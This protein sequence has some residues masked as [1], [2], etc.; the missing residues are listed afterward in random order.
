MR[1]LV[2]GGTGFTGKALVRRLLNDG[3]SVIAMDYKEG[4]KTQELRDWGAEVVI[5]SVTDRE[6]VKQCM[7]GVE[8]VQHVAAAF[9][10]MNVPESYYD[11]VNVGGTRICL[12]EAMAAGVKKFIYCSTCGVHG[13][14]KNPPTDEA[15]NIAPADYYQQTKYNA[16]PVVKS[17]H[18]KGL[19]C[20]ILRPSAIYGPGDPERFFMIYRRAAKGVFPMFGGGKTLYHPV[21]IDNLVDAMVLAMAPGKGD[22][23]V[24]L[25]ADAEYIP[26]EDLVK[27]IGKAMG[28]DVKIKHYPVW[29][30]VIAGHVCEKICKPFKIAP[31]I[32]PRRVDW[33]RQNRAFDISA[34]RRDLGYDP[35]VGLDEGLKR[36]FEWYKQEKYL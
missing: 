3:H 24:Y 20:V 30:L 27:R 16:E 4:I 18:E 22:G 26:I 12:E 36:T 5:G 15:H 11:E 21:Y 13:N 28:I 17:F 10:E 9:R 19:P 25:I 35:K 14:V 31:P 8:V 29:P 1:I 6:V 23:K 32:F 34:A 2:T 7:K 33:Y